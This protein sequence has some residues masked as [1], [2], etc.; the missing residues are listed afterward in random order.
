LKN[1]LSF[2]RNQRLV[3]KA[4][5]KSLFDESTKTSQRYLLALYKPNQ[6]ASS[7]LGIIVG[8]RVANL[9]VTRNRIKRIIRESF[10][11]VQNQLNG[12]DIVVIARQQC[13][14][15]DKVQLREGIEKLWQKLI[16]QYQPS[17]S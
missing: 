6:Q 10:R 7:R 15:L 11:A 13:G 4:E 12:L 17:S 3:T 1:D 2:P 8:K 5:F 14:S 16:I 9:A